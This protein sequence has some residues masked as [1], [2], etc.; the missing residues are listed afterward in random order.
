M[1]KPNCI[2]CEIVRGKLPSYKIYEDKYVLAFA[3]KKEDIITQGH[4]LIIPK[5]HFES[6]YDIPQK[7]MDHV[8]RAVKLIARKLRDK[9]K[10]EGINILHASGEVAQQSVPH[11]HLHLAPRKRNDGL[12]TWPKTGY[13]EKDFPG[14]YK[15][16]RL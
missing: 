3:P 16:I 12:D 14:I 8:M 15:K 1:A 2:F 9:H 11:F 10:F 4:M 5:K 7:E 13:K 6:I